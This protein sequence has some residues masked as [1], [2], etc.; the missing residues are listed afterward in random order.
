MK[1]SQYKMN[2]EKEN[3]KIFKKELKKEN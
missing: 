2:I 3:N 1:M